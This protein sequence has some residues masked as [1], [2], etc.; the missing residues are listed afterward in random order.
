MTG[1]LSVEGL[2]AGYG[3]WK[4]EYEGYRGLLGRV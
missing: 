3:D 1:E 2:V 4:N